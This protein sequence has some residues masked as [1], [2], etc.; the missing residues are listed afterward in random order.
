MTKAEKSNMQDLRQEVSSHSSIYIKLFSFGVR[1]LRSRECGLYEASDLLLGDHLCGKSQTI[2]W[3]DV[4]QPQHRM[5]RLIHHSRLVELKE[6]N[7][8]STDIFEE[9]LLDT[10]YPQ[11]PGKI[12]DICVYDF[13]AKYTKSGV[14][15]DGNTVYRKLTKPILLNHRVYNPSKEDEREKYFYSLLLLFVPFRDEGDLIEGE[16]AESAFEWHMQENEALN[17]HSEKLQ[18]MLRAREAVKKINEA[19]QAQEEDVSDSSS[20][21]EEDG[22]QVAGEA[23]SAMHDVVDLCQDDDGDG[24]SLEELVSSLN[25]DQVHVY[26]KVKS[27]LEHQIMH[28]CGCCQCSDFTPLHMFVSGVGGTGKSFLIKTIHALVA[29]L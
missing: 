6:K 27:H 7:P 1:S 25:S 20:Q 21:D 4:S 29:S 17:T 28:K 26:K 18:C 3:I 11:R 22:P 2:N 8:D 9:N 12:E 13:V 23:I 15:K 14:D 19:R 5:R 16:T 10:F 24:P